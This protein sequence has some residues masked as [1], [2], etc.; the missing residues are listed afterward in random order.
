MKKLPAPILN[1]YMQGKQVARHFDGLWNEIQTDIYI[2][3][4]FMQYGKS[5]G[6][7]IGLT[8]KLKLVKKWA[9]GK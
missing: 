3:T 5:P 4:T 1:K 2:E 9:Y 7:F 8:F 6:E